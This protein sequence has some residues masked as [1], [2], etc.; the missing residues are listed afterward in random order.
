MGDRIGLHE[1]KCR[2]VCVECPYLP[3]NKDFHWRFFPE[4]WHFI[5]ILSSLRRSSTPPWITTSTPCHWRQRRTQPWLSA[6]NPNEE[7]G[8]RSSPFDATACGAARPIL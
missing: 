3:L 1:L 5:F 7:E 4:G 8:F 6:Q 2:R